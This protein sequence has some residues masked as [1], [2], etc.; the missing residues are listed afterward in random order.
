MIW[1]WTVTSW[2]FAWWGEEWDRCVWALPPP[3]PPIS[4]FFGGLAHTCQHRVEHG[5][6]EK[7][8]RA[9]VH[10][11]TSGHTLVTGWYGQSSKIAFSVGGALVLHRLNSVIYTQLGIISALA[12]VVAAREMV[13][14]QMAFGIAL[15]LPVVIHCI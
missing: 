12:T 2:L 15:L 4:F 9:G 7:Y 6:Q 13:C 11:R 5:T 1:M 8:R 3:P 10:V 14:S